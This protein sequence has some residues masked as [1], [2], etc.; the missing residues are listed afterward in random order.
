MTEKPTV[1]ILEKWLE[2]GMEMPLT[3]EFAVPLAPLCIKALEEVNEYRMNTLIELPEGV[4]ITW[5]SGERTNQC[6]A[7]VFVAK[8]QLTDWLKKG[9]NWEKHNAE[10]EQAKNEIPNSE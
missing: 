1:E 6:P 7:Y 8:F 9:W 5:S 4:N 10:V 2:Y 3:H